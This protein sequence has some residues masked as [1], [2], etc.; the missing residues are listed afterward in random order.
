MLIF[1]ATLVGINLPATLHHYPTPRRHLNETMAGG[2]AVFDYDRDGL[3]DVF[4]TNGAP[5]PGY[6]KKAPGDCNRLFRNLGGRKFE[7]VTE[8]V[9]L[10]GTGYDFAAAAADGYL[11]VGGLRESALYRI[12]EKGEFARV[13]LPIEGWVVGGGWFDYDRDGDLDLF[14]VRYV[15]WDPATEPRCEGYCHPREYEGLS[16]LLFRNDSLRDNARFIDVS[17]K[18]GIAA[19]VGKGM[20][21]AFADFDGDG[22]PDAFVANDAIPN[23]LFRNKGDGTFEEM[24]ER[25]GVAMNDDGRALSSMGADFRDLDNDGRPDLF[26]TALRNETFPFFRNLGKALFEDR[27]YQSLVGKATLGVSGW[28]CGIYD[29]DNDGRKDLFAVNGDVQLIAKQTNLLLHQT[30][31]GRF[32]ASPFGEP[33]FHRGVAFGD[34]DGDGA[35]DAVITRLGQS[36]VIRWGTAKGNW[37]SVRAPLGTAVRIGDQTNVATTAV[38]YASSSSPRIHFGLGSRTTVERIEITGPTGRKR[39]LENVKANQVLDAFAP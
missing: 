21:V 13:P 18:S 10:C 20:S 15:K 6:R 39:V 2:V 19:H 31:D 22:F 38:G 14:V 27:T 26:V 4:L 12:S 30:E 17:A 32:E 37:I 34:L 8:R 1:I 11:F 36:P 28:G 23:F 5:P 24:A 33:A 9:G 35:I 25:A 7:D 16:N 29:F 3:E